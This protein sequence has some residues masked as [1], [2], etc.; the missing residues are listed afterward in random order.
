M[1]PRHGVGV[2]LAAVD[3]GAVEDG[4]GELGRVCELWDRGGDAGRGGYGDGLD[5]W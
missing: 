2:V 3:V 1:V 4:G 5:C